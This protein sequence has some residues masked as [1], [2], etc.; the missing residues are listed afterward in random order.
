MQ[1]QFTLSLALREQSAVAS[2]SFTY[3]WI[4][5][6]EAALKAL[7]IFFLS[8]FFTIGIFSFYQT[9][10]HLI[11]YERLKHYAPLLQVKNNPYDTNNYINWTM[12]KIF[13]SALINLRWQSK[14]FN[15]LNKLTTQIFS[16]NTAASPLF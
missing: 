3:A 16:V 1:L 2:I 15:T 11:G 10:T 12:F 14:I 13:S 9:Y 6:A 7:S 5:C 8:T 4:V